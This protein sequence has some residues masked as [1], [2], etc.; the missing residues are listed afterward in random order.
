MVDVCTFAFLTRTHTTPNAPKR[1]QM[2]YVP[3]ETY[4]RSLFR[5]HRTLGP[6]GS[7][8]NLAVH[9]SLSSNLHNVKELTPI[10][11]ARQA[12]V[13]GEPSEF[14][15][16]KIYHPVARQQSCPFRFRQQWEPLVLG[17]VNVAGCRPGPRTCQHPCLNFRSVPSFFC[18]PPAH[19]PGF[20]GVS[21]RDELRKTLL[22]LAPNL[23]SGADPCKTRV[24]S[25]LD[26][27]AITRLGIARAV[28]AGGNKR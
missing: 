19:T 14:S 8:K 13:E 4:R 21:A 18:H 28:G 27:L 15:R 20:A 7:R 22:K 10:P 1:V 6:G 16:N 23:P 17:V 5:P 12:S 9:V 3:Q 2:V 25:A 26:R 24:T 11:L